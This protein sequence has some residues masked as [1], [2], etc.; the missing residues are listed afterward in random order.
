MCRNWTGHFKG[1]LR[2]IQSYGDVAQLGE[3]YVR[4]VQ[5][6]GSIPIISTISNITYWLF[7]GFFYSHQHKLYFLHTLEIERMNPIYLIR[8]DHAWCFRLK[9]P[10]DLE[11]SNSRLTKGVRGGEGKGAY[12]RNPLRNLK[13]NNVL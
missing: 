4:N 7:S 8:N 2:K 11:D 1:S 5:V 9:V 3:R 13:P 6:V 12:I 10:I